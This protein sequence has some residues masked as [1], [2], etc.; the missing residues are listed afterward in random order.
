MNDECRF[1]FSLQIINKI[2]YPTIVFVVF[3]TV[4]NKNVVFVSGEKTCHA[5]EVHSD[6]VMKDNDTSQI[7]NHPPWSDHEKLLQSIFFSS[8]LIFNILKVVVI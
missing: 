1:K 8:S 7:K 6:K 2:R 4:G 3:L 5:S